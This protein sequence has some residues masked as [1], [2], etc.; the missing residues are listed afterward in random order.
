MSLT[1]VGVIQLIFDRLYAV[2]D[3]RDDAT[4]QAFMH[5][6][7]NRDLSKFQP[8]DAQQQF[9]DDKALIEQKR[10][11]LSPPLA[12]LLEALKNKMRFFTH[13]ANKLSI[14]V[15]MMGSH[16]GNWPAKFPRAS[17]ALQQFREWTVIAKP[18]GAATL[19]GAVNAL[20]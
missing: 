10:L 4:G 5:H 8:W 19:P 7:L 9:F 6:L 3:G 20:D 2:A 11:S 15:G 14:T 16:M 18:H 13:A 17:I 1:R 12:W